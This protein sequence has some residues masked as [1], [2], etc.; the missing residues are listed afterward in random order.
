M[1]KLK[2]IKHPLHV[3]TA[4]WNE[5]VVNAPVPVVVDFWAEWCAPCHIIAPHIARLAEEYAGRLLVFKLDVDSNP[6]V[7]MHYGIQSIPTVLFM[8]KGNIVDAI[9]GAV[10]YSVFKSKVESLLAQAPPVTEEMLEQ[11]I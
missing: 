3:T 2:D 11:E 4:E 9:I 5:K 6:E 1:A 10:P 8:Y 7:A